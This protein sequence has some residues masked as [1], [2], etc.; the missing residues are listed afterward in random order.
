MHFY[1]CDWA[2]ES[3]DFLAMQTAV[4]DVPCLLPILCRL[5][6][7]LLWISPASAAALCT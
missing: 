7:E 4:T 5:G 3:D 6:S 2:H 1:G